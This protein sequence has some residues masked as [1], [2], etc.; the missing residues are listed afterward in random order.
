MSHGWQ[1]EATDGP[2]GGWGLFSFSL[3]FC[4]FLWLSTY[5][6]TYLSMYPSLSLSL[7]SLLSFSLSLSLSL[8]VCL[9]VYRSI[10]LSI[11][12]SI[13]RSIDLSIYLSIMLACWNGVFVRKLH[14]RDLAV[15]YSMVR[16]QLCCS[17]SCWY[18]SVACLFETCI[19]VIWLSGIERER[20]AVLLTLMLA[21]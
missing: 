11:D 8:S 14:I 3:F 21:C 2:T 16:V 20:A 4:L 10:D 18:V 17:R 13:Y 6:P 9:S 7:L 1:R 15:R 12:L 5:L 19:D